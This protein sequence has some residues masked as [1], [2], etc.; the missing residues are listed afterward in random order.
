MSHCMLNE[1]TCLYGSANI[2]QLLMRCARQ[3]WDPIAILGALMSLEAQGLMYILLGRTIH[4]YILNMNDRPN[5][6]PNFMIPSFSSNAPKFIIHA[7]ANKRHMLKD[8][9]PLSMNCRRGSA[10]S[11]KIIRQDFRNQ[12]ARGANIIWRMFQVMTRIY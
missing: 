2:Y 8:D 5:N 12:R 3:D 9:G 6:L 10:K 11:H 1:A 7:R 4:I